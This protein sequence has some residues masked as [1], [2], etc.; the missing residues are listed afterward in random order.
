MLSQV[1]R[2]SSLTLQYPFLSCL[3]WRGILVRYWLW[4]DRF[5]LPLLQVE[6]VWLLSLH[7]LVDIS[8]VKPRV[9]Y[10]LSQV[11]VVEHPFGVNPGRLVLLFLSVYVLGESLCHCLH[12]VL[13][14]EFLPFAA[15]ARLF[16]LIHLV[17]FQWRT[18]VLSLCPV[19]AILL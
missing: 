2:S 4:S 17:V 13:Q 7:L 10:L 19:R 1:H 3:L 14:L 16:C 5:A 6:L 12:L 18:Q 8:K 9:T 15:V 11:Q